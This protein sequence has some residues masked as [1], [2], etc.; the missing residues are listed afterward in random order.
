MNSVSLET[1]TPVALIVLL[2]NCPKLVGV[3]LVTCTAAPAP[4]LA[5][6]AS[7]VTGASPAAP[8]PGLANRRS[9]PD[10]SSAAPAPGLANRCSASSCSER[11]APAPGLADSPADCGDSCSSATPVLLLELVDQVVQGSTGCRQV[12]TAPIAPRR[13]SGSTRA[14]SLPS[15]ERHGIRS[16]HTSGWRA[17][18]G[19][20]ARVMM[21]E[22]LLHF[23]FHI[24]SLSLRP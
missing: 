8:A 5:N 12:A 19:I 20:E 14:A 18:R 15:R 3:R 11:A 9:A 4:G 16:Y 10:A 17:E 22:N 21:R 1:A 23:S 6:R 13:A 2:A 24:P 7:V